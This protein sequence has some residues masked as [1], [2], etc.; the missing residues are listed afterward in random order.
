MKEVTAREVEGREV[1]GRRWEVGGRWEAGSGRCCWLG[2]WGI[3]ELSLG[4]LGG[5]NM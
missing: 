5:D 4:L 1:E 2:G 3:N